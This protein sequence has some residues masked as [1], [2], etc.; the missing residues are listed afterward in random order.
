[1]SDQA[2]I[3][4]IKAL[5]AKTEWKGCTEN[6]ARSAWEKARALANKHKIRLDDLGIAGNASETPQTINRVR[7][8]LKAH[9]PVT[10]AR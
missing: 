4:R 8:F 1:M 6:E 5:L 10:A 2:A 3:N 7:T 9:Q